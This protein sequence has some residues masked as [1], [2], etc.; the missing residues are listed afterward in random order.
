MMQNKCP[1]NDLFSESRQKTILAPDA[2]FLP[3][4]ALQFEIQ[5]LNEVQKIVEKSP[6]RHMQMVNGYYMSVA[7][8]NCGQMGWVSDKNGYRYTSIDPLTKRNWPCMPSLF[9]NLAQH[10]A[11]SAGFSGFYPD[12][13][14]INQYEPKAKLSLHQDKD[15]LD[16][17]S[18]IV[19]VSLGLP[20]M[21][22][23]GGL[24]RNDPTNCV[25][26]FHGDVVVWGKLSRLFYHGILPIK[27][28]IHPLLGARRIN[29]TFRTSGFCV[30]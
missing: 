8:T 13:C 17:L 2:L 11:D 30:K 29:L 3:G 28:G 25:S 21:F 12:V 1:C 15:E 5:L 26:L 22:L 7:T 20:A 4:F 16:L 14:L 18:P 9:L 19:S 27:M 23:F 24:K 10:A 6:L